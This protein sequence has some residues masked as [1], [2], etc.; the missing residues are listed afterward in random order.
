M[1]MDLQIMKRITIYIMQLY[2]YPRTL[3]RVLLLFY[4]KIYHFINIYILGMVAINLILEYAFRK[5][6]IK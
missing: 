4:M 6:S 5:L 1:I 2:F 3:D